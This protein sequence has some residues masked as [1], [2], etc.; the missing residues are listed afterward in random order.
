[1]GHPTAG[2][3]APPAPRAG[4]HGPT[5][6]ATPGNAYQVLVAHVGDVAADSRILRVLAVL[7]CYVL[8]GA[9]PEGLLSA[10]ALH[11]VHVDGPRPCG[12]TVGLRAQRHQGSHGHPVLM[13]ALGTLLAPA[14]VVQGSGRVAAGP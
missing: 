4:G 14:A 6:V 11:L 8:E 3:V 2:P 12:V 9:A 13:V 1:M 5:A 7:L 10:Q